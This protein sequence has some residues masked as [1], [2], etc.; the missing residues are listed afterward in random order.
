MGYTLNISILDE[1]LLE[2]LRAEASRRRVSLET[3]A[4]EWLCLAAGVKDAYRPLTEHER[5]EFAKLGGTWTD[6][7]T[8]EFDAAV[9]DFEQIDEEM[10]K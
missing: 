6:E 9:A 5:G 3:I 4:Q 7:Q 8:A 1:N 2:R 10:W